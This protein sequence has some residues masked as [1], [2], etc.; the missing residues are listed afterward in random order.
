MNS[1]AADFSSIFK[2]DIT[3]NCFDL[4]CFSWG[5]RITTVINE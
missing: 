4:G 2:Y 5:L 3:A 1:N